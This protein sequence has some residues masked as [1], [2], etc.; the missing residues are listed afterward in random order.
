MIRGL[1]LD[2]DGLVLETEGPI[3]QS[4][5]E[6]YTDHG[7]SLSHERWSLIIGASE[8]AIDPFAEL[9]QMIGHK[10]A[11]ERLAPQRRKR[12]LELVEAQEV[13]PGVLDLLNQ[14]DALGLVLGVAS[15][16]DRGWV[17]GHLDRLGLLERFACLRTSDDVA[18]AKPAPDLYLAALACL[19]LQPEAALAF[20]DSAN[21]VAA[22]KAAG[23]FTVAVPTEM[24]RTLDFSAADLKLASLA[25][26]DL[27]ALMQLAAHNP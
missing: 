26:L 16:S 24:T 17:A 6:F 23:I 4:W 1:I 22:A 11:R 21:G 18:Q 8:D 19:G 14:A 20:E 5:S 9:E 3:F 2:F 12:E 25:D 7:A 15:S 13:M 27:K 10:L